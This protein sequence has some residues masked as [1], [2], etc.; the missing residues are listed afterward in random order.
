MKFSSHAVRSLAIVMAAG[1]ST[2]SFPLATH[3]LAFASFT[4]VKRSPSQGGTFGVIRMPTSKSFSKRLATTQTSDDTSPSSFPTWSYENHCPSMEWNSLHNVTVTTTTNLQTTA[5]ANQLIL[6][7]VHNK[8][9]TGMAK[10]LDDDL[11]GA[12]TDLLKLKAFKG[13]AG[14]TTPTVRVLKEN[15][16]TTRYA[17]IGLSDDCTKDGAKIGAAIANKM[18][19]DIVSCSMIMPDNTTDAM[20]TALTSSFYSTL[21]SDN[22]YKTGDGIT[23][24]AE[25]LVSLDLVCSTAI[26]NDAIS[27]GQQMASGVVLTKDIVNAPHNVLNSMSLAETAQRL[28]ETVP[29]LSCRILSTQE[30]QER[31]MGAF[32]AVGRGSET[33]PQFIHITYTP[34]SSDNDEKTV[35][36]KVGIIGKG[37]LMDTGGY[38]IKTAMMEL[39]KFD[40]GGAGA[41]LG[42]AK[43]IG[44]MA[45][46]GVEAHFFVAACENMINQR[47]MVPGDILTASNGKTIEVINTDAEG[48]LTLA[49]ALV[50]ADKEV[51]CETIIE[52]S[53]LTGA[54]MISL[55]KAMAGVWTSNDE[56]AAEIDE[57]SKTSGDK[58]WRMP[59]EESYNDQLKSKLADM[60]N[61]GT[62]YGGAITAALFLQNFVDKEK[63]FCHIDIAGPV[64]DDKKGAT[65]F[66][67]KLVTE[68]VKKQGE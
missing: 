54:C 17:L 67:A 24:S 52:L 26:A 37:L 23:K 11:K 9:L 27:L 15:G 16:V 2:S 28:A 55:G 33:E 32:L 29:N 66:G 49:D 61:C 58:T 25:S 64:W 40:C 53:T 45:P 20:V 31:G 39:M 21:Y 68:W 60:T 41:V 35:L 65:G 18:T 5:T 13:K 14:M 59:L 62:K 56:L 22:R 47:A 36:K 4:N 10:T 38:N 48:R 63:P 57:C 51:G 3:H 6:L 19:E 43:A 12:L 50:Y 46:K 1:G 8:T 7:G 30:C 42:A 44:Q 34:P